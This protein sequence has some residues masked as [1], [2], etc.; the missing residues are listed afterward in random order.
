MK[1]ISNCAVTHFQNQ[2]HYDYF[3]KADELIITHKAETLGVT[4][5]YSLFKK[6]LSEELE[7]LNFIR[8][9]SF[10]KHQKAASEACHKTIMNM[11]DY[12]DSCQ[13]H[14]DPSWSEAAARILIL[15][16][17]NKDAK[18]M[19][20][21]KRDAAIKK[22]DKEFSTTYAADVA[23]IG[24]TGW[25]NKLHSDFSAYSSFTSS[26]QTEEANKTDLR[27]KDTRSEVETAFDAITTKINALIVVNGEAKYLNFVNELNQLSKTFSDNYS[28]RN[29]NRKKKDTDENAGETK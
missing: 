13:N 10:S 24:L 18:S 28:I 3:S 21:S 5:E 2:E 1:Q 26:R 22:L 14:Y 27:M 19:V 4:T 17:Q 20:Q 23:A 9:N 6:S 8:A 25:V 7:S 29:A 16:N 12:I 15:W 11:S